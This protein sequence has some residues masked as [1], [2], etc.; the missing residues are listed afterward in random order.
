[1]FADLPNSRITLAALLLSLILTN[2]ST[3]E[4]VT[5]AGQTIP[6]DAATIT[7][8]TV[9][10]QPWLVTGGDVLVEVTVASPDAATPQLTLNG[11]LVTTTMVPLDSRRYQTL[12]RDLP[13][14]E[15]LIAA[16]VPSA[17]TG[18]ELLLTNYPQSGPIISGPQQSPFYC[19]SEEFELVTGELLG[20]ALDADCSVATRVDYVYL[21]SD[22]GEYLPWPMAADEYPEDL[23]QIENTD[24]STTPFIV[25]V[26]TGT[27]NR[28]IYEIA[29]LH[30]PAS[31]DVTP[32]QRSE[33]WNGKL[34]YTHGGGCRSGWHQQGTTTGGVLREGLFR[35]GYA[36]VSATLNVF[37]QNCNDLLASETH[38]MVKE[39]FIEQYGEPIYTIATGASGGSYQSHQ[40]ADNYPGV[41]DGLIV[42]SS[43]PDVTSATIFTLADSRLLHFY[44]NNINPDEFSEAQQ[45]AVAGFGSFGSIANLAR[46]AARLDPIFETGVPLEEQGGEVSIEAL[47]TQRY[48]ALNPD[49]V[50]ATVYDHTENVYGTLDGTSIAQRPLD[51]VG[52]Q[53]GLAALNNGAISTAQFLALNRDI[54]GFDH[55]INHIDRRHRADSQA[56]RRAI[57]SGRILH[58]G[59]GLATTPVIDYR[60]YTDD[61]EGGD[62]HMI[63]HQFSTRQRLVNANGHADNHIMQVGGRWGFTEQEPDLA[64]LFQQMDEWLMNIIADR[65]ATDQQK[66]VVSNKPA[67]LVDACWEDNGL[68]RRK[69]EVEQTYIGASECNTLYPAYPTPRQVAGAPLAN[70][71]VSCQLRPVNTADYAVEFSDE[72]WLELSGIFSDGVCDW[73]QNDMSET[74]HQGGWVSF[75][76]SPINRLY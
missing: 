39:R 11:E 65:S 26:E 73:S 27:A 25:R 63:V 72:E 20:P 69:I 52:V 37:G 70:D 14:G 64:T 7:L 40:T 67:A 56:R 15:S 48:H 60:R 45:Q 31:A 50:R 28:A 17:D 54:G 5:T 13:L 29:M 12:I 21:S 71:I 59:T 43:F 19:Q 47:E 4:P 76:P 68:V 30:D 58:G 66:K 8:R 9:S 24:G 41:F 44:F 22:S 75:G 74:T 3:D 32:W 36:T 46:G 51:N 34:V 6:G 1:M 10:T 62:I 16:T 61:V 42:S 53:Y 18:A 23:L 2:C 35:Q 49:G 38:I 57:E 55:D 33:N